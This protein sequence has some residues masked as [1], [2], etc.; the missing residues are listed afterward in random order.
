VDA[1]AED[2][3]AARARREEMRRRR[4]RAEGWR[5][6]R[7]ARGGVSGKRARG[8]SGESRARGEA[9]ARVDRVGGRG[10]ERK[11]GILVPF[12]HPLGTNGLRFRLVPEN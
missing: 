6:G 5:W 2:R 10:G 9:T 12:S 11:V 3:G 4:Q 7:G 8:G 1:E